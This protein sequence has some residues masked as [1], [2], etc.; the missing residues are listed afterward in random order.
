MGA[1][2]ELCNNFSEAISLYTKAL[3]TT[4][5]EMSSYEVK[6]ALGRAY[7]GLGDNIKAQSILDEY[8]NE[9]SDEINNRGD[10]EWG[11]TEDGLNKLKNNI[12]LCNKLIAISHNNK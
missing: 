10:L 3:N 6:L 8:K 5:Y 7:I 12:L 11:L 9:A 1:K 2:Q 4:R